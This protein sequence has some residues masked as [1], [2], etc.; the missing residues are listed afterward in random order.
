MPSRILGLGIVNQPEQESGWRTWR[1]ASLG[2]LEEAPEAIALVEAIDN[3]EESAYFGGRLVSD[4]SPNLEL[5][6]VWIDRC[7]RHHKGTCAPPK[8]TQLRDIL[9]IDVFQRKLVPYPE[10]KACEYITLSY[11]WGGCD[12]G[13]FSGHSKIR[14]LSATL[15][16][17]IRFTKALGRTYLWIDAICI[18]QGN[19]EDKAHSGLYSCR[20]SQQL[21]GL[22][23]PRSLYFTDDQKYFACNSAWSCEA[24]DD[25][26]SPYHVKDTLKTPPYF[27]SGEVIFRNPFV[28]LDANDMEYLGGG[29]ISVS[30]RLKHYGDLLKQYMRRKMGYDRD[31]I[32][33]FGG[34]IKLLSVDL[35]PGGFLHGLPVEDTPLALMW[36][37][38][39]I[40][41]RRLDFPAWSWAGWEGE[42]LKSHGLD[43]GHDDMSRSD[44][45]SWRR[46]YIRIWKASNSTLEQIHLCEPCENGPRPLHYS[47]ADSD[48]ANPMLREK[49]PADSFWDLAKQTADDPDYSKQLLVKGEEKKYLFIECI[50]IRLQVYHVHKLRQATI[51]KV[52]L[53][54]KSLDEL[55]CRINWNT[56]RDDW[57][58]EVRRQSDQ[59][60]EFIVL[61]REDSHMDIL[62]VD[63][64]GVLATRV[65]SARFSIPSMTELL[66]GGPIQAAFIGL[67]EI[68][69]GD[70]GGR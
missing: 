19:P 13:P 41:R 61:G 48:D 33:A 17:A 16:D 49:L 11:V 53:A 14:R 55:E 12:P 9:L 7:K 39:S 40:P 26:N 22:L 46:P 54:G 58:G 52:E 28:N 60:Q 20:R 43:E 4:V 64:D 65:M 42:L 18:N 70:S 66:E 2:R 63:K 21:E 68:V 8:P 38:V 67:R 51:G 30:T 5:I 45:H 36:E 10:E 69:G 3:A 47:S 1:S 35:Y 56:K 23:S 57:E 37:P 59:F 62:M 50:T 31:A 29:P 34:I 25:L 24:V 15:E 44:T 32:N 27:G 6:H